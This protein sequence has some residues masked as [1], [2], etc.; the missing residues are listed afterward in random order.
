M[1]TLLTAQQVERGREVLSALLSE[2]RLYPQ[3]D[4]G[5]RHL[6]AELRGNLSQTLA[7]ASGPNTPLR[8]LGEEDSN[9]R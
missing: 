6:E 9:P 5:K 3:V 7:L 4:G 8:W 2:V 1:H